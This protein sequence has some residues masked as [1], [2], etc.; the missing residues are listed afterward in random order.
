[1]VQE[2][3]VGW[4]VP[5]LQPQLIAEA[6]LKARSDR[7]ALA[8][9]GKRARAVAERKYSREKVIGAYRA[10]IQDMVALK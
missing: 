5:P 3:Q 8:G 4:I 2:E 6:I 7:L 9:M 1:V 10:M